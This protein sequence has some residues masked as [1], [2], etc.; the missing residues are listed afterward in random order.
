MESDNSVVKFF[1]LLFDLL[2]LNMAVAIVFNLSPQYIKIES[3][4]S[5]LYY[6]HANISE[7]IAYILYSKRNYFF[8][9]KYSNRWRIFNIRFTI[10]LVTLFLFAELFLPNNYK[11]MLL[12]EYVFLFYIFK[13]TVFYFIYK[14]L[15][16]RYKKGVSNQRVVI[17]GLSEASLILGKLLNSNPILGYKF[18]GYISEKD[19]KDENMTLGKLGELYSIAEIHKVNMIFVTNPL[20]FTVNKTK[21]LL[22][23]SNKIG[24]RLRYILMNGYW[25]RF[26]NREV[27]TTGYFEMFNPQEI[28]LD[29]FSLRT[30]KRIFDL[31][32]SLAVIMFIF[33][34]LFP[35]LALVIKLDSKGPIFFIQQ[36]T[37]INN[38]TFNCY[39]FRTMKVNKEA[40]TLQAKKNDSR[41]TRIGSFLRHYNLDELPQFVNV[42]LGHMSVVGPRPHML[43][44]TDQYAKL[45]EYYK[46]RHFVKPGITGWA[47]VNG[48]R[49]LT[50]ELWKMEKRV[51]FDMEYLEKWNLFWDVKIILMTLFGKNSYRNAS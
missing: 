49:G 25:N 16:F 39:K 18:V 22:V 30:Q 40:N 6:L 21:E 23:L 19:E 42:L 41:I 32:F 4:Q 3:S 24:L 26:V 38:K 33:T 2:L 13:V 34:W 50:D 36:R 44:H 11:T 8:T 47:Q 9:D 15:Q 45:I 46:V 12:I 35:I 43:K 37:G 10:L 17:L 27:E 28:P 31:L 51:E 7:I 48:Y 29:N 5:N 14:I 1:F 20:Y